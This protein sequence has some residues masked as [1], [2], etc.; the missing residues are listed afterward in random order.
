MTRSVAFQ[1]FRYGCDAREYRQVLQK[2]FFRRTNA[3]FLIGLFASLVDKMTMNKV[4]SLYGF[5]LLNVLFTIWRITSVK[6]ESILV[7]ADVGVQL[8]TKYYSGTVKTFFLDVDKIQD[9]IINEGI[10]TND[11]IFYL[12]ILVEGC[13]SMI[14]PF[15]HFPP[16]LPII[17][18][19]YAGLREVIFG[20]PAEG[21][22]R[23]SANSS[24]VKRHRFYH[25][26]SLK[27]HPTSND[28]LLLH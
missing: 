10:T 1:R 21:S 12:C 19:V 24:T 20:E 6:Q 25:S 9:I 23:Q 5:I 4:P 7:I 15:E 8:Q 18:E 22:N 2:P 13:T 26:Q 3:I 16:R 27:L 11:I 28:D 14:T 17:L